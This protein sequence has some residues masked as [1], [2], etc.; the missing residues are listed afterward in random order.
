MIISLLNRLRKNDPASS[1][2]PGQ[3][4]YAIGDMHGRID[5]H[6]ALM[7]MIV[8]DAASTKERDLVLIYLGDYI[9]RGPASDQIIE[10]LIA[11]PPDGFRVRYLRGNHEDMLL[12]FIDGI[13]NTDVW[14]NNGGEQTLVAYGCASTG[15]PRQTRL[16]LRTK[17]PASH[18]AFFRSLKTMHQ[19][20]DYLFVHAGL[21]PGIPIEQQSDADMMWIRTAFLQSTENFG[22]FVIHG[23]SIQPE[24]EIRH[25]RIGIDTGAWRTD[26]LTCLVLDGEERKFLST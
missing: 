3:R 20:G 18:L 16:D 17:L 10:T 21:R 25:N 23:H 26:V 12:Q 7:D 5:L 22:K 15:N 19:E 14:L 13:N 2:K 9:D 8:A 24:P 6:A 1:T 4:I 11:S